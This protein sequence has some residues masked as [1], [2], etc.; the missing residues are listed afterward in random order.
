MAELSPLR[1]SPV[2]TLYSLLIVVTSLLS[3][4]HLALLFPEIPG[5]SKLYVDDRALYNETARTSTRKYA[6]GKRSDS[7]CGGTGVWLY[8]GLVSVVSVS[9]M[10][11]G[12]SDN[13]G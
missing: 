1:W 3:G 9:T 2:W 12:Q 11:C 7:R 5:I 4:L 13:L 8:W 6:T 10:V